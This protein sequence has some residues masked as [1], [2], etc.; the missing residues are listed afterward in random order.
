MDTNTSNPAKNKKQIGKE[1][2]PKRESKAAVIVLN[3]WLENGYLWKT[4]F[5]MESQMIYMIP[6][7]DATLLNMFGMLWRRSMIP[8][9]LWKSYVVS[10]YPKYQMIDDKFVVAQS[11]ELHDKNF[12]V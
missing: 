1:K 10:R 9:I 7:N 11:H 2:K 4:L 12:S 8:R 6:I 5:L 3:L